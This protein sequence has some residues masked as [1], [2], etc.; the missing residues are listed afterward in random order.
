MNT[1]IVSIINQDEIE[2]LCIINQLQIPFNPYSC[3]VSHHFLWFTSIFTGFP[4]VSCGFLWFPMVSLWPNP[5]HVPCRS[6]VASPAPGRIGQL[7]DLLVA[8][9]L[10]HSGATQTRL[11][12]VTTPMTMAF[13]ARVVNAYV[14]MYMYIYILYIYVCVLYIY[15]YV[16]MYVRTYEYVYT[17]TYLNMQTR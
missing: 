16:C 15:M 6:P 11:A 17:L 13:Y 9:G 12:V 5:L 8:Q 10:Q 3:W 4:M 14:H 1:T 2:A 7:R